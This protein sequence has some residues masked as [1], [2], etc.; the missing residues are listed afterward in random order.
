MAE[1]KKIQSF[2]IRNKET[3]AFW[4][5][6]SG[7]RVWAKKAHAKN[8][9]AYGI[10]SGDSLRER[11]IEPAYEPTR[12][13][14]KRLVNDKFDQQDLYEIVELGAEE[15]ELFGKMTKFIEKALQ[16]ELCTP[17]MEVEAK[18]ILNMIKEV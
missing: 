4:V 13:G 17:E 5:A 18:E 10:Y 9:W 8:A 2:A 12:W 15:P 1:I 16:M 11:G 14:G 7:K 6:N 3:G